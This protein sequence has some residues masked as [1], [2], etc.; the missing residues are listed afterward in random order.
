MVWFMLPGFTFYKVH[1]M[2]FLENKICEY[3]MVPTN[4]VLEEHPSALPP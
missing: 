3:P 1:F 4:F 2:V